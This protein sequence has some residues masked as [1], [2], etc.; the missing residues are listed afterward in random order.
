MIYQGGISLFP[1]VPTR[2]TS[3][4][5]A[6]TAQ[7]V[8][9]RGRPRPQSRGNSRRV[10][11]SRWKRVLPTASCTRT[12]QIRGQWP[13][14]RL[15]LPK[16]TLLGQKRDGR[17]GSGWCLGY[18]WVSWHCHR[19]SRLLQRSPSSLHVPAGPVPWP[20]LPPSSRSALT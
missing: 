12:C 20:G 14:E 17:T 11:G 2:H 5:P 13:W 15:V 9:A 10:P 3:K 6:H 19:E 7:S 18:G 8:K 16:H 4:C 1:V